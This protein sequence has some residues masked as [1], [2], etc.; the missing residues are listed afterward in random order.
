[1][2]PNLAPSAVDRVAG[3]RTG[4]SSWCAVIEKDKHQLSV[5]WGFVQTA[6]DKGEQFRDLFASNVELF[7]QFGNGH[8][9]FKVFEDDSHR[10]TGSP[11]HPCPADF[12]GDTFDKRTF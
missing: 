5:G 12:A 3:E 2:Y 1:M 8:A 7:Y 11:Q 6:G 9:S 10:H 4:D